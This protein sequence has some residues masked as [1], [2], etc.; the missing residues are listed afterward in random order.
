MKRDI[1]IHTRDRDRLRAELRHL[2]ERFH[3][4][5]YERC[6]VLFGWAWRAGRDDPEIAWKRVS[7]DL[8]DVIAEV[9]RAENDGLGTF[10]GDDVW[11]TFE[12]RA[13]QFQFCHHGGV[14]LFFSEPDEETRHF[15][16]RWSEAGLDPLE[17][18]KAEGSKS[19]QRVVA[20]ADE[21]GGDR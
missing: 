10:G 7:I 20:R 19:W 16:N 11:I 15:W 14:H 9:E 12:G 6:D 2:V 13:L 5:G 1:Q 17:Y 21:P 3:G 8:A 18:E 4:L